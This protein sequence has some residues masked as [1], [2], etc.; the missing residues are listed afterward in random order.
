[1]F[2]TR[3]FSLLL[4]LCCCVGLIGVASAAEVDSGSTYCFCAEDFSS[5][6]NLVGICITD[7]PDAVGT[8]QLGSRVL[9]PGDIL[10]ADQ[11]SQMTFSPLR[12]EQDQ[13]AQVGY[14]PIFDGH[15]ASGATMTIAIRGKEDKAPVAED[16]AIETYKNLPNTAKLKA[17]D[18]EGEAL[19]FCVVRQPKRGTVTIS[20]DGGFTYTPKKNKVGVD[21]FTYTATDPAG[22]V[23]REATVTITILKPSDATQYTDTCGKE[24][25]FAAEWMK[26]TGIFVGESLA[27]KPCFSPDREVTRG[28][29][30]TMLVKALDIPTDADITYTGYT[31]DIPEWLQPYLAAAIRSGLT[32]GL[33][34]QE[35]FGAGEVIT[36]AEVSV[37]LQNALEL[38]AE[39]PAATGEENTVPAWAETALTAM[40]GNG[41]T[42]SADTPLTR[43]T[44]AQVLYQASKL[45][46]R[47]AM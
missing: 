14:L 34:N 19:T 15:V 5:E 25:R 10:T 21:S 44:A 42:L 40:N 9:R 43:G 35:V 13:S 6:E 22:K 38:T 18:P 24:C 36:G 26:H 28:E 33:P 8:V 27:E 16:F 37:M 46:N 23:S 31:D 11:V 30:V 4:A 12:T 29:F 1:M 20:E 32:A 41:F 7:L 17:T 45:A 2:Q 47:V 3:L 39:Q